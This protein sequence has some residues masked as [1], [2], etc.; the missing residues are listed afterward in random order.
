[1]SS[2]KRRDTRYRFEYNVSLEFSDREDL[3][4]QA[5]GADITVQAIAVEIPSNHSLHNFMNQLVTNRFQIN[6]EQLPFQECPVQLFRI[7][8][9]GNGDAR[10]VFR[11]LDPLPEQELTHLDETD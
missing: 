8:I 5:E 2:N 6:S 4:V 10:Y 3:T 11:F 7:D 9:F 1:M